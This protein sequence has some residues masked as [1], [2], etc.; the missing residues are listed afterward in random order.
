VRLGGGAAAVVE[1]RALGS[2]RGALDV[3]AGRARD[4]E[5][6]H[7]RSRALRHPDRAVAD[8][9]LLPRGGWLLLRAVTEVRGDQLVTRPRLGGGDPHRVRRH[10]AH[11]PPQ[12]AG[13]GLVGDVRAA[14]RPA[15]AERDVEAHAEPGRRLGG[16]PEAG[17]VPLREEP[18]AVPLRL[19]R[20]QR[21]HGGDLDA[22]DAGRRHRLQLARQLGLLDEGAEPPPAHHDPAVRWWGGEACS[23]RTHGLPC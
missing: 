2:G 7:P 22:A 5:E 16:E 9:Q 15:A 12:P 20:G 14:V 6:D 17:Q 3:L 13:R 4:G 11:V 8:R 1:H 21:V 10:L 23:Q 19:R 18:A